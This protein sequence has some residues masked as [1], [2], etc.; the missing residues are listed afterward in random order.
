VNPATADNFASVFGDRR[1]GGARLRPAP[2]TPPAPAPVHSLDE[3][4]ERF[5][6]GVIGEFAHVDADGWALASRTVIVVAA[7]PDGEYELAFVDEVSG[8][9]P[10][11][12]WSVQMPSR[13]EDCEFEDATMTRP[14]DAA[15]LGWR[16]TF[17]DERRAGITPTQIPV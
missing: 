7:E 9:L 11:P 15:G 10:T 12:G 8:L 13:T 1:G 3:F 5:I 2:V 16:F 14:G 4:N 6:P 17:L